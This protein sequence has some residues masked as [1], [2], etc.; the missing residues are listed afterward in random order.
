[1]FCKMLFKSP[2][3]GQKSV[4]KKLLEIFLTFGI[5]VEILKNH[6]NEVKIVVLEKVVADDEDL[7]SLYIHSSDDEL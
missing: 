1:M 3:G 2:I 4:F 7:I 5:F 6:Q